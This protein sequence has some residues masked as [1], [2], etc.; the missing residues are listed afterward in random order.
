MDAL[1][2]GWDAARLIRLADQV[3]EAATKQPGG[4]VHSRWLHGPHYTDIFV[5]TDDAGR[6]LRAEV[7]FGGHFAL[8]EPGHLHTGGTDELAVNDGM[9]QSRFVREHA[10][11]QPGILHAIRIL[12]THLPDKVLGAQLEK[13]FALP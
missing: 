12:V 1:P 4:R 7:S 3:A 6:I 11:A 8:W 9:P 10:H 13:L 2:A 5:D